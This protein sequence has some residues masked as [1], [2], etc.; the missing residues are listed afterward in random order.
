MDDCLVA[1]GMNGEAVRSQN[2]FPLRLLVPGFEG[3]FNSKYLRRIKVVDRY[4]M[5]YND[6]GHLT[7]DPDRAALGYQIGPKSVIT[8]PS[9]GQQL[10]DRGFYEVGGLAWSGG[11]PFA[12]WRSPPTAAGAGWTLRFRARP[13]AWRIRGFASSGTGTATRQSC[14]RAA[15]MS[16]VRCSRHEPRSPSSSTCPRTRHSGCQAWTIPFSRGGSRATGAFTMGLLRLLWL[17]MLLEGSAAAQSPTYG[18]GRTPTEEEIRAWISPSVLRARSSRRGGA[19]LRKASS[20]IA[21]G[22]WRATEQAG[23]GAALPG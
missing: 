8:F 22:A 13:T 1:Y 4:Y 15:R 21:D 6:Y 5:T 7:R 2:G 17:L 18:V 23:S 16:W 20:S 11:A 19:P 3:I 14:C 9:A 10:P 12:G